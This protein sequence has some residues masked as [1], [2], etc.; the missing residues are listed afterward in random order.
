M[1]SQLKHTEGTTRSA[2]SLRHTAGPLGLCSGI[3]LRQVQDLL[4][5]KD[6][7][8]TALY[9]HASDRHAFNPALGIDV[10]I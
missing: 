1:K 6:P 3:D 9:A 8:I 5:Q 4:G 7:K 10:K 2:H